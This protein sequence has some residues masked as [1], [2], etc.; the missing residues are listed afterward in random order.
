MDKYIYRNFR[1]RSKHANG[2]FIWDTHGAVTACCELDAEH[3]QIKVGFSFLNPADSQFLTRGR[4]LA[5]QKLL[6]APIVLHGVTKDANGKYNITKTILD[7]LKAQSYTDMKSLTTTL[8]IRPYNGRPEK[9]EFL[10]WFPQL[11]NTL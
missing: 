10:K 6:K 5:K 2:H 8:G 7:H 11:V 1:S 9:C 4:G 3:Q